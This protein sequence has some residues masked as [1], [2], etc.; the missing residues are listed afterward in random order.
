[1]S[2]RPIDWKPSH[3]MCV[4]YIKRGYRGYCNT[5]YSSE[6][7]LKSNFVKSCLL[8]TTFISFVKSFSKLHRAPARG[9]GTIVLFAIFEKDFTAE[10]KNIKNYGQTRLHEIENAFRTQNPHCNKP[11]VSW[12]LMLKLSSS[13]WGM[14]IK[15][16]TCYIADGIKRCDLDIKVPNFIMGKLRIGI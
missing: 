7:H 13:T 3:M 8:T 5:G 14:F 2:S 10:H 6:T 15:Y 4:I 1:M 16:R 11:Q 12:I 9:N